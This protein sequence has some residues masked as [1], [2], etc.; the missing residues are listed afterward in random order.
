M[1]SGDNWLVI[2]TQTS[3]QVY[4]PLGPVG[5]SET[6]IIVVGENLGAVNQTLGWLAGSTCWSA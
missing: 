1:R 4:S 2:A 5:G 6:V 3:A